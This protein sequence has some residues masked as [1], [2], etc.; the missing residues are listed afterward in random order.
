MKKAGAGFCEH[1][2]HA[3]DTQTFIWTRHL[4][5]S[6]FYQEAPKESP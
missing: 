6:I 2:V 4:L 5:G 1:L 3:A